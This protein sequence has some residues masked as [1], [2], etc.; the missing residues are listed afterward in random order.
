MILIFAGHFVSHLFVWNCW[1]SWI[2]QFLCNFR[3]WQHHLVIVTLCACNFSSHWMLYCYFSKAATIESEERDTQNH[4]NKHREQTKN[5]EEKTDLWSKLLFLIPTYF[6][7]IILIFFVFCFLINI[8]KY[9]Q[10]LIKNV[11][12]FDSNTFL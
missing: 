4:L 5:A 1:L 9:H 8:T 6:Q 2:F 10:N 11:L 12:N 3:W 7:F